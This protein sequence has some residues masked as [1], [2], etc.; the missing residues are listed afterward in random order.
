MPM[1]NNKRVQQDLAARD[2]I[3]QS[4][5]PIISVTLYYLIVLFET[6]GYEEWSFDSQFKHSPPVA[7]LI[8]RPVLLI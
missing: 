1:N 8:H 3:Q 6:S 7:R 2:H 4:C 5:F